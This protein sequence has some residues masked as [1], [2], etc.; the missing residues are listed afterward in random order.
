MKRMN[1]VK[2]IMM[3]MTAFSSV[4]E[5]SDASATA[6]VS[7]VANS[8]A[9]ITMNVTNLALMGTPT[10]AACNATTNRCLY[11]DKFLTDG[12]FTYDT[13]GFNSNC[14]DIYQGAHAAYSPTNKLCN[15]SPV[16][17]PRTT[18]LQEAQHG[19]LLWTGT[20]AW[21]APSATKTLPAVC[22][23]GYQSAN[24]TTNILY[25]S[26]ST[27]NVGT[28]IGLAGAY[29][30]R[31]DVPNSTGY[32]TNRGYSLRFGRFYLYKLAANTWQLRAKG[33]GNSA[34]TADA[35]LF[36][37]TVTETVTGSGVGGRTVTLP[38]TSNFKIITGTA[39]ATLDYF[40]SFLQTK[41]N[42]TPTNTQLGNTAANIAVS[43]KF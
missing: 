37:A 39:T 35:V 30:F 34:G 25:T 11:V 21:T 41:T 33:A 31:T 18:N 27:V 19:S 42:I 32:T 9:T 26:G 6:C 13:P 5:V 22:T 15:D 23:T 28:I 1:K 14:M 3:T 8:S 7:G 10:G 12:Q 2:V 24:V 16:L 36:Q 40:G 20:P 38:S 17:S 43:V 29:K 4:L